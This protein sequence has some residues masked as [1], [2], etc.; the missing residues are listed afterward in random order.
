ML[1]L[2]LK[3]LPQGAHR[4]DPT[5]PTVHRA[6]RLMSATGT[7]TAYRPRRTLAQLADQLR[8]MDTSLPR[9][10]G[11]S[12]CETRSCAPTSNCARKLAL[13]LFRR[14]V[15]QVSQ[16]S[17]LELGT[18]RSGVSDFGD[19]SSQHTGHQ[20][21]GERAGRIGQARSRGRLQ[22]A[23]SASAGYRVGLLFTPSARI[24]PG[25]SG[26]IRTDTP[27]SA[28]VERPGDW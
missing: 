22:V 8:P 28:L 19:C 25:G 9:L 1:L 11:G 10:R 2:D 13:G 14:V 3:R 15:H 20:L 23:A 18:H 16:F 7:K 21:R 6:R 26:R 4:P 27:P 17:A 24:E 12:M 5:G